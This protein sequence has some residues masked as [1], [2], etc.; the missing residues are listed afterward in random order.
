MKS[1]LV[2][3]A[4]A[5]LLL[6]SPVVR[7]EVDPE[8]IVR[9]LSTELSMPP[10]DVINEHGDLT[11]A[12]EEALFSRPEVVARLEVL[13]EVGSGSNQAGATG[14]VQSEAQL[15]LDDY[16]AFTTENNVEVDQAII[17]DL[18][19]QGAVMPGGHNQPATSTAAQ[20]P[21]TENTVAGGDISNEQLVRDI[22]KLEKIV[23]DHN[24]YINQLKIIGGG[25]IPA[26]QKQKL[27]A[28]FQDVVRALDHFNNIAS[29]RF[30]AS[31][32]QRAKQQVHLGHSE[33]GQSD[34]ENVASNT[35][36][37]TARST[38][39]RGSGIP[40]S[41][42]LGV[43]YKVGKMKSSYDFASG[44][45]IPT[46]KGGG[47]Y[48]VLKDG[49]AIKNPGAPFDMNLERARAE[50]PSSFQRFSDTGLDKDRVLPPLQ[51]G[52]TL[53]IYVEN[54]TPSTAGPT[55]RSLRLTQNGQFTLTSR[56][57]LMGP[58]IDDKFARSSS[59]GGDSGAYFIDGNTIE[60]RYSSGKTV[61]SVFGTDGRT[62]VILG[63]Q[64]YRLP[65]K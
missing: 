38:G 44:L 27:D 50:N 28:S 45:V 48:L 21:A 18:V 10:E 25:E 62:R 58:E 61:R 31:E 41:S 64:E 35:Q 37:N 3:I 12:A 33:N 55:F 49:T 59:S 20:N 30:S 24:A 1:N 43:T 56:T 8:E 47:V 16:L 4:L 57:M 29:Q 17:N 2:Y 13:L 9:F 53:D 46:F 19:A 63:E 11:P 23:E 26:E 51:S 7:A 15:M 5:A 22:V 52:Y 32:L 54:G 40:N 65:V 60:L 6:V 34:N 36:N 42:I 14:S 39:N